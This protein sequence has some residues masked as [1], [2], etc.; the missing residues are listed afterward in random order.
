[1]NLDVE[2]FKVDA[3]MHGD[4]SPVVVEQI[5]LLHNGK[6]V[7]AEQWLFMAKSA[8]QRVEAWLS[9]KRSESAGNPSK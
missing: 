5:R 7:S 9:V 4:A 8:V 1:M 6:D 2:F 3:T